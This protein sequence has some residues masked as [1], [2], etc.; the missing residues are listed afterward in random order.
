MATCPECRTHY[1][2]GVATC[3]K[4]GQTLVPDATFA[5]VD[6]DIARG[7]LIGEYRVEDKLGEGGF[8]CVYRAVHPVIGKGVAIKVLNRQFSSNPEMVSRFIAE[9]RAANQ[10][11]NKNIIDIFGFG[12]LADGR[13]FYVMELLEGV[14]LDRHLNDNGRLP[15]P[16][17]IAI[18]R[19][20]ARALDAAHTAGIVHRDLKPENIFLE[21]DEDRGLIPKL[22]DFGIAKLIGDTDSKH[23]TRT[24]V[25]IGTP[26]YMSPEQCRGLK[27]DHKT[28]VY[29]FGIVAFQLL[30]GKLPFSGES[31]MDVMLRHASET[32]PR[33]SEVSPDLPHALDVPLRRMLEKDPELRP[34]SASEALEALAQA[35]RD[36][37]LDVEV[38]P[39][40]SGR[41]A[42]AP[43]LAAGMTPADLNRL[44]SAETLQAPSTGTLDNVAT[45]ASPPARRRGAA[46]WVAVAVALAAAG[47]AA[48]LL[49][50]R[51]PAAS[52]PEQRA[53]AAEPVSSPRPSPPPAAT[54]EPPKPAPG[55]VRRDKVR[56]R[57]TSRPRAVDVY[58]GSDKLGTTPEVVRVPRSDEPVE[59]EFRATGFLPEKVKLTPSADLVVNVTLRPRIQRPLRKQRGSTPKD[60]E[61]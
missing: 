13:Q 56:L 25:P 53:A 42:G 38:R 14:T 15:P 8:G 1:P 33:I 30:T 23:R 52:E 54:P 4:D 47:A 28:D 3:D 43:T 41:I 49:R 50:P 36:S 40:R 31:Y 60:L 61:F 19:G 59:L 10:I 29:S 55:P 46:L 22:L 17:A 16:E 27:I 21:Y 5:S 35:A 51:A 39:V 2:D 48:F 6:K 58:L 32:P 18:L 34:A 24:G 37:G 44:G 7:E 12:A 20:V 9:A 11:R 57:V 45:A 26:Y